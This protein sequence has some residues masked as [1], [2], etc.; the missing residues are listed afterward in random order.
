MLNDDHEAEPVPHDL[1]QGPHPTQPY[2]AVPPQYTP[3]VPP[4]RRPDSAPSSGSQRP[5]DAGSSPGRVAVG[6]AGLRT[7]R[8]FPVVTVG[9]VV[10]LLAV[11]AFA[12]WRIGDI[13]GSTPV[14][15]PTASV[16]PLAAP[17][18]TGTVPTP[19]SPTPSTSST[20]TADW[21][22]A[23]SAFYTQPVSWS[24]CSDKT[25]HQCATIAVPVDYAKPDGDRFELAL[26]KVSAP[27]PSKQIGSLLINPG[28]PGGSGTEYAQYA[29]FVFSPQVRAS[30]DIIGFDPRGIGQSSPV[31]CLIDND[32]DLLFADDP[33]PD[34][35]AE[36]AKLLAD[37]DAVTA[38]CAV[39]G[40]ERARHMST[41]EVARDMDV[42]RVLVG[43]QKLNYFGVSYGTM[44][45]ALYADQFPQKVGRFVLDSAI[46][47]NQTQT[48]EMTYDIQGFESSI[49][50]FTD[51]CV[52][53]SDCAL[54]TDRSAARGKIVTLLDEVEKNGLRTSKPGLETIGEGWASFGIFMCLYSEQSWPTL[55]QGLREALSGRGDTLLT[56]AMTVVGRDASGQF[57]ASSYLQAMIPVRCADWPRSPQ[58]PALAAEEATAKAA[59]PL[60]ARMTGELYDNCK[61]WPAAGRTPKGKTLAVG[62]AP[63][64]V[65]GN[66]RDPATPIG[67]TKQLAADLDSG[68]L[69]TSDHDGHGTYY[70]GSACVDSAVD[71]YLNQGVVP[72]NGLACGPSPAVP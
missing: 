47:P 5:P 50:A 72:R 66:L 13:G 29:S 16:T 8:S 65:I 31:G 58:T 55:N 30:Y 39:K 12:V 9:V 43:D 34:T 54:G 19:T 67:G 35:P 28:G 17:A 40:G 32:M 3:P 24:R 22:P 57:A 33:T 44:L 61:S 25:K 48:Q 18:T 70:A 38:R 51:W 14:A 15:G 11:V 60:W 20:T 26:R 21:A 23:L 2:A 62:A 49:D 53:R 63:I 56:Q 46:S 71:G 59:H 6:V 42:I 1:P 68:T 36:K 45:G 41:A 27:N 69:V 37:A 52:A 10:A 4:S 7:R 64:L